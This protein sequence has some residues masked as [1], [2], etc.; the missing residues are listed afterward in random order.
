MIC[1]YI[2]T[3]TSNYDCILFSRVIL[4]LDQ[5]KKKNLNT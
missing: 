2:I 1:Q 5:K 4:V 3:I